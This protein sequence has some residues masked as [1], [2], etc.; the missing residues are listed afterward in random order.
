MKQKLLSIVSVL[1]VTVMIN[2]QTVKE[3]AK[4]A[5]KDVTNAVDKGAKATCKFNIS[6]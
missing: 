2:A 6:K 5:F 4:K 1:F 3:D